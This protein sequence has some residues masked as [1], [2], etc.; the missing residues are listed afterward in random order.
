MI[1]LTNFCEVNT[2]MKIYKHTTGYNFAQ[3]LQ[4]DLHR[5]PSFYKSISFDIDAV[6]ENDTI[7]HTVGTT[8]RLTQCKR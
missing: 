2:V 5:S 8:Y 4:T 1:E 6:L 3:Q 7:H